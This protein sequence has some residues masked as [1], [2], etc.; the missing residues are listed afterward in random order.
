MRNGSAQTFARR[1]HSTLAQQPI[2]TR[3]SRGID[4]TRRTVVS[5]G[6]TRHRRASTNTDHAM[7]SS[8]KTKETA[9][10]CTAVVA[11]DN[12]LRQKQSERTVPRGT[13]KTQGRIGRQARPLPCT[14]LHDAGPVAEGGQNARQVPFLASFCRLL[15]CM[16]SKVPLGRRHNVTKP[17]YISSGTCS[18]REEGARLDNLRY[19]F[20]ERKHS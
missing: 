5:G 12:S 9:K 2:S 11:V 10:S 3:G 13:T 1:S 6:Q 19:R 15:M 7:R 20:R 18:T 16:Q 17:S 4:P 8:S 14:C